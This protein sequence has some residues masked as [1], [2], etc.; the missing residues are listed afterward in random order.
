MKNFL[1]FLFL[2]LYS[3]VFSQFSKTHY[4]PPL[5]N[6]N[7]QVPQG[8]FMYISCPSI[9]PIN[10]K[11]IQ[12]GG[13]IITGTVSR[14]NPYTFSIGSGSATQLMV[15]KTNVSSVLNNK[16]FIVEAE[17]LVYVTVRL[18]ATPQNYQAGGLVSKGL[19]ALGTQFRVG[20]FV[21]TGVANT[22][23]YH[24]T[25][26]A[27]LATENNTSISFSDISAGV[28]LINNAGAGN[29]P[30]SIILNSGES[31]VFAVE[32]PTSA[33]RDGLIG[34][35]ITSNKPI[36][37][38]CGSFAGT[39]GNANNLDLGF[40]QIVSAERTGTDYIFI[41]GNGVDITERPLI[42]A[43]E[44]ATDVFINGNSIPYITL[45]AGD[46]VA[47]DGSFF[48]ANGNLFVK[49][50]KKVFAYQGIGGT[51][52][53]QNQNMHF[54]P[55]LSCE[56]PKIINN[57]PFIN[58][59]GNDTSYNG[60][61]CVVTETGATLEFIIN[62]VT[63]SLTSL[64]SGIV[65][66]GPQIVFGNSNY[67]TY[68][69]QGLNGNISL[70]SSK[71]VYLSYFGSSGAATYGGFYSGFTFKP[72][73][74]LQSLDLNQPNCIPFVELKVNSLTAFDIFQWYFNGN[75][76]P[77]ATASNYFPLQPGYYYVSATI[78][79]CN[80]TLISD[81][82]P[83]SSCAED[84]DSDLV[85]DNIDIDIDND[86]LT[87]C[88]ESSGNSQLDLSNPTLTGSIG[89]N[90]FNGIVTTG[91]PTTPVAIPFVGNNDGSFS[92]E[93]PAGKGNLV[94]YEITFSQPI[95]LTMDYVT[96]ANA[97][98]L[99]NSNANF[100]IKSPINKTITV[101]NPTNQLLI[102]T[103]YDGIYETGV[104]QFSSFEI[105]F[106]LNSNTPLAAGTGTFRF[107]SNLTSSLSI[108]QENLSDTESNKASFMLF[109]T[110]LPIDTDGD[111]VP[112]H[113]D[114]DSDNDGIVDTY[115]I[116]SLNYIAPSNVDAN[117][118]GLDDS[119]E[120]NLVAS[121]FDLDGI[122]DYLDLDSD[123]DG[124]YDVFESG[125]GAI[126]ANLDGEIDGNLIDFGTN[127]LYNGVE[128]TSDSGILNYTISNTDLDQA[129]NYV[130]LDSDNDAC[131]DVIEA[132][133]SDGNFDDLLGN[134]TPT[135]NQ[136]G[137]VT[138]GTDG[139]SLPNQNYIIE[140]P[141]VITDQPTAQFVCELQTAQ[142]T[143]TTNTVD[144]HQWQLSTDGVLWINLSNDSTYSNVQ[145]NTLT[146]TNCSPL[147]SGYQYR[148]VL[149][150]IGNS[151]GLI[152][153][154]AS[155]NTYALPI[156][157][158]N[159]MI[160]CDTDL[161]A[162]SNF[163]L[164]VNNHLISTNSANEIFSYYTSFTGADT[165]N[166]AELITNPYS[167]SN[168]SSPGLMQVWVR[169]VNSNNCHSVALLTLQVVA[170]NIPS[171]FTI[172]VPPVCDDFLDINGN[173]NANNDKRDGISSFNFGYTKTILE[174]M[175]P[176][177]NYSIK[178]YKNQSDAEA[179]FDSAGNSLELSQ[180]PDPA[181]T[182]TIFNYR[183]IGY[184]GTQ[185]IWVR[186]VSDI[187]NGCYGLGPFVSLVVEAL[188]YAYP[189]SISRECDDNQ[190]GIFIFN[191]ATL[192]S[193][194]VQGQ[195]NVNITYY[196][197]TNNPL[198]D[199]NGVL[200][201]SPFPANFSTTSQI[202]KAVVTNNSTLG[203]FD[204]TQIEFTIDNSP[205]DFSI[206]Q[207]LLIACDDEQNPIFQDGEFNFTSSS[208]INNEITTLQPPG[209]I[210][211]Y[212]DENNVLL[213]TP[214][215][216]PLLVTNSKV[217][218]VVITNPLNPNC[219]LE[220]NIEF[221][222]LP[223]PKIELAHLELICSNIPTFFVT[224]TAGILDGSSEN[225]YTYIWA[226]DGV[227]IPTAISSTLDVNEEG[228]Y[229]VL[230]TNSFGCSQIRTIEV[231]ASE[232]ATLA[233]PT[234]VDLLDIC[235]VT[236]NATGFGDYVYALDSINGPYQI[237]S[238]FD[239]VY[240]GIHQVY[241]KDL[242]ECGIATQT[243]A[244]VG[245][246]HFFTPNGDG[247]NDT[248]QIQGINDQFYKN[249]IIYIYDRYGKLLKQIGASSNGWDG[250]F[251]GNPLPASDYWFTLKLEDERIL[252][253]H[254]SLKR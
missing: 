235:T 159:T 204:E 223:T 163:N 187:N 87:N 57:I 105:R 65:V 251:N 192:E 246:P 140:A 78:S 247:V 183:N 89:I 95:S 127:G 10:F 197:A 215:P 120:T 149:S 100:K 147:M 142:F 131:S 165:A 155:L 58:V 143:V 7:S 71:Q 104:T 49:T 50:S 48:S 237:G 42:V 96:T 227:T 194:L 18:S 176:I 168:S 2:L 53:Q 250:T 249:S 175:L 129:A 201:T 216:N 37:V 85:N 238:F 76:I 4:I 26:A 29:S 67:V 239:N 173:N 39:N 91:G 207:N 64:P 19:A 241:V 23:E 158:N 184:P 248:W 144:G 178:Y 161:D 34:A 232:Q 74:S 86:G 146:I 102:D 209:L 25:F 61:V 63:Y 164:T 40:D 81:D 13:S 243:I 121:D 106:R 33:N 15:S 133:F 200:I 242:N 44:N 254:F 182:N 221:I 113:I 94:T 126:D 195:T 88:Q 27:I 211:E 125:S 170:T 139:Y 193:T 225:D 214:L 217:I 212:Y 188:P 218:K 92:T 55:P 236:I 11:I 31:Y 83:V 9:T 202:I 73:I 112:N 198:V 79:T 137:L 172:A 14:D 222:V 5:S 230:V 43:N 150:K 162:I 229:K 206:P 145:S 22:S 51:S 160:Q 20:A 80:S 205:V 12:L 59:V 8:Q 240:P 97:S 253:G 30:S 28:S 189:V 208:E 151:C 132:G 69:F 72:E 35:G 134:S 219:R 203:C 191:T 46:Y 93:V 36:A 60:T 98:D 90:S 119:Y 82:I 117:Q 124:I 56:T 110:C 199:S 154:P 181:A 186:I 196:D 75:L 52:G 135:T 128:T 166:P 32:G 231:V 66:N 226:K 45:N 190:D 136:N 148:V 114:I 141:I 47:L 245:A 116:Q 179:E 177:G 210:I 77:G 6:S 118:N 130:D 156:V 84:T 123:N 220:K 244:V 108:T 233:P 54:V 171:T 103:N 62:G 3:N 228:I 21:N 138:N 234:I 99:I 122:P 224:L 109:A 24:Y 68:T 167:F 152:S 70:F 185:S 1:L 252:K 115:E 169:V 16:G 107:Q 101:L 153:A 157:L 38:N 17:D 111:S 213:S 174:G 180:N 41:K